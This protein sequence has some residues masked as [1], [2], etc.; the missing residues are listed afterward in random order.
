MF[1]DRSNDQHYSAHIRPAVTRR[2][3]SMNA[4]RLY[5]YGFRSWGLFGRAELAIMRLLSLAAP[6]RLPRRTAAVPGLTSNGLA[7]SHDVIS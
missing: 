5:C 4:N 1:R 2:D 7:L 6:K 3:P